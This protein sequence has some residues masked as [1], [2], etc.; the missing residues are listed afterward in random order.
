MDNGCERCAND[1]ELALV[2]VPQ[3]DSQ[4]KCGIYGNQKSW[5]ISAAFSG[6]NLERSSYLGE[7]RR[8]NRQSMLIAWT[9]VGAILVGGGAIWYGKTKAYNALDLVASAPRAA[10]SEGGKQA[11]Q[12]QELL[13][14]KRVAPLESNT[15]D[16]RGSGATPEVTN[17]QGV[18]VDEGTREV[19]SKDLGPSRS[20]LAPSGSGILKKLEAAQS[21]LPKSPSTPLLRENVL[22]PSPQEMLRSA[23]RLRERDRP[24]EALILYEKLLEQKSSSISA[25]IGMAWCLFDL[26]RFEQSIAMFNRVLVEKPNMG[27]AHMG[28]AEIKRFQGNSIEA[29]KHYRSYL[30]LSP[31][32]V[33]AGL[34]KSMLR[35]LDRVNTSKDAL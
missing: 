26:Q 24:A 9:L 29:K 11:H 17:S 12:P 3:E 6:W 18:L 19:S 33:E 35:R 16:A 21:P 7:Y 34:A 4:T 22:A 32:G 1:Y 28:L 2:D 14:D 30:A 20:E 5:E 15:G 10:S 27:D 8:R 13:V 25:L 23:N 31:Q